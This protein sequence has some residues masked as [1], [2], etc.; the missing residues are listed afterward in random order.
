MYVR[1]Y[2]YFAYNNTLQCY[3]I[4]SICDFFQL[5]LL[6]YYIIANVVNVPYLFKKYNYHFFVLQNNV[7]GIVYLNFI[8]KL[9]L[10][11]FH[12]VS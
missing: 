4:I 3:V 1:S 8:M 9:F 7:N 2:M 10:S 6:W 11:I 5:L 12:V